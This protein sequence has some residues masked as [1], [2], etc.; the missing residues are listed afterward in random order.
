MSRARSGSGGG[1]EAPLLWSAE[2]YVETEAVRRA[3][4]LGIVDGHRVIEPEPLPFHP[5]AEGR[6]RP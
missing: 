6:D 4:P 2:E 1:P 3:R 5:E